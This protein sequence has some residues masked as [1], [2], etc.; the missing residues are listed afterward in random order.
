MYYF[1]NINQQLKLKVILDSWLN[2]PFKHRCGV[3]GLGC[4]CIHFAARVLEELGILTWRKSLV[5]DYP[6]D[7][8]LH[9]TRE[10]LCEAIESELNVKKFEIQAIADFMN[11][12]LVVLHIGKAA[13]HAS[14]F[15]D[16]YLYQALTDCGVVKI[17]RQ[18]KV[19]RR[20][21]KY[22]YRILK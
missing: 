20:Q 18:D 8:H 16:D 11:G 17:H 22:V 7:W 9:N 4:D 5:S 15:F 10:R 14:I 13:A 19:M 1:E 2:T 3:K 12:D 6:K 21:M